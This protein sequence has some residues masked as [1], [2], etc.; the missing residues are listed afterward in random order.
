[1]EITR[2]T[3]PVCGMTIPKS[4]AEA[5]SEYNGQ[6]YYFCYTACKTLFD[7]DPEKYVNR[8]NQTKEQ[9]A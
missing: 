8:L 7:W 9:P 3:D 5:Q 4:A 6:T 2:V 1:M